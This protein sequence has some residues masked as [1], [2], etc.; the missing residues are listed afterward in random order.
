M[1]GTS[2]VHAAV[3]TCNFEAKDTDKKDPIITQ[4]V[5]LSFD[6]LSLYIV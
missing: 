2:T 4:V 3:K 1:K 5:V 6:Y